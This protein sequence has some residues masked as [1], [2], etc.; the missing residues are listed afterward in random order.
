MH[1][2]S[3]ASA[4]ALLLASMALCANTNRA[5][6]AIRFGGTAPGLAVYTFENYAAY[7]DGQG[8]AFVTLRDDDFG[9]TFGEKLVGQT[10]VYVDGFDIVSGSPAFPLQMDESIEAIVGVNILRARTTVIDGVGPAGH[11]SPA[12]I[13]DGALT[14][15]FD[16]DQSLIAFDV[17]GANGGPL[18]VEFFNRV[19]NSL[20]VVTVDAV[21][22]DTYVYSSDEGDIAAVTISNQDWGGIGYDNFV[23]KPSDAQYAGFC[24]AGDPVTLSAA[25]AVSFVDLDGRSDDD[26]DGT[27]Y[28][29]LWVSDCP[30]AAFSNKTA[31]ETTLTLRPDSP[32]TVECVA[33]LL[34]TDGV[35]VDV[36]S[37]E[38]MIVGDDPTATL[39]CPA[40]L[41]VEN[42][43]AG[44]AG[45]LAAWL[46]SVEPASE[47]V[48]NDFVALTYT[49]GTSGWSEVEW[50]DTAAGEC[51]GVA[52][53]SAT[54]TVADT[55]PPELFVDTTPL[56]VENLDCAAGVEVVT[57][58][59]F[60]VD[61]VD[62]DLPVQNDAPATFPSGQT[63]TVTYTATDACGNATM[64]SV[65]ITVPTN[66]GVDV[67]VRHM[68]N[69]AG[70]GK[71]PNNV[72]AAGVTV[73][74]FDVGGGSCS[75]LDQP[76]QGMPN[77]DYATIVLECSPFSSAVTDESGN[78][79][80][81][82]LVGQYVLIALIDADGDGHVD[83][84]VGAPTGQVE[85]GR[86]K[87]R[88]L[89]Y[90]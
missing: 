59:G 54:F 12:G 72:P 3:F 20:G 68:L 50:V 90:R 27:K 25:D 26:L 82:V 28:H 62:G 65:E 66:A 16:F 4:G 11:P 78:A 58:E 36:C 31:A 74:A 84:L 60:A 33:T 55:T 34:L 81:P 87:S 32:C 7:A 53:C 42:D 43:G 76:S 41:T 64:E 9:V 47:T 8:S 39:T 83:E 73:L 48:V 52:R 38:V 85:C 88:T 10:V 15:H 23:F 22:N 69:G 37:T 29:Y 63:T 67:S 17:I 57:P 86:W 71:N 61:I 75:Y 49:C 46:G 2:G 89:T 1:R 21:A 56:V 19:G 30:G 70:R 79:E 13:G 40:D 14:L 24:N 5:C 51:G 6:G 77:H 44:N 35:F 18:T 45:D 80:I